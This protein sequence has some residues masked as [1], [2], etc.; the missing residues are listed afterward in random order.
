MKKTALRVGV[1]AALVS[2]TGCAGGAP[3]AAVKVGGQTVT[4]AEVNEISQIRCDIATRA[5]TP[6]SHPVPFSSIEQSTAQILGETVLDHKFGDAVHASYDEGYLNSQAQTYVD[7]LTGV[8]ADQVSRMREVFVGSLSGVLLLADAG[9]KQLEKQ[10][11]ANSQPDA[12]V[13]AGAR[14]LKKWMQDNHVSISYDPRYD[15]GTSGKPGGGQGSLSVGVSES[16]LRNN[17]VNGQLP[18]DS[19]LPASQLCG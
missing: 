12:Q 16:A 3:G 14:L 15:V 2:L 5:K 13:Q 7:S 18:A 17:G 4:R 8:P 6:S 9:R 19:G 10:G 1:V 11:I